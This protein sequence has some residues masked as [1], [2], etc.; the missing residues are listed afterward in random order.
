M[1]AW[2]DIWIFLLR[3][4]ALITAFSLIGIAV[5]T[6]F[7]LWVPAESGQ[8]IRG[9]MRNLI[10]LL[11]FKVLGL[12]GI[13]LWYT[14]FLPAVL[15][16]DAVNGFIRVLC[17]FAN[18]LLID[19]LFYA[20]HRAQHR[21]AFLWAIHELHHADSELN[22]TSSY[23][24]YWLEVPIQG[25]LIATPTL[26]LFGGLGPVHGSIVAACSIF[27]LIF[28]HANVRLQLGA[29]QSWVINPQIHR[30]HH[31]RLPEHRDCNFAQIF[32]VIDRVFGTFHAPQRDEFPPTGTHGMASDASILTTLV[33]PLQIW[34]TL[35]KKHS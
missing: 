15:P 10:F 9:R 4:D 31:S 8:S 19:L 1:D 34:A 23:R 6:A 16:M 30:I 24:T 17:I 21:F 32:P 11:I 20:Y 25:I 14:F 2:L 33:R 22:A 13:A 3:S 26:F 28:A 5:L 35:F 18:L 27:F 29:F 12:G 7:E